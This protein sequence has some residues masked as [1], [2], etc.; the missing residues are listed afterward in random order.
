MRQHII[1]VRFYFHFLIFV[2][3]KLLN[4]EFR[5]SILLKIALSVESPLIECNSNNII[6][7][8]RNTIDEGAEDLASRNCQNF[9]QI[10]F[11]NSKRFQLNKHVLIWWWADYSKQKMY[12]KDICAFMQSI[13]VHMWN[14]TVAIWKYNQYEKTTPDTYAHTLIQLN[15][16]NDKNIYVAWKR[17][18]GYLL[19]QQFIQ[20]MNLIKIV[21]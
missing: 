13:T 17:F 4:G 6:A 16:L 18:C 21:A 1:Y 11:L 15:G 3:W 2:P 14:Y 19:C 12:K 20:R 5:K 8:Y 10:Y 7:I 9:N